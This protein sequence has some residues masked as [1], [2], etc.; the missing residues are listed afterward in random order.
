MG[1]TRF[2]ALAKYGRIGLLVTM[3]GFLLYALHAQL[4]AIADIPYRLRAEHLP[5]LLLVAL[6]APVNWGIEAYKW[7]WLT[8]GG[9]A[10]GWAQAYMAVLKGQASSLFAGDVLGGF[11]GRGDGV[12]SRSRQALIFPLMVSQLSQTLVSVGA[13]CI[14]IWVLLPFASIRLL[15][16][17]ILLLGG[18][19]LLWVSMR[20]WGPWILDRLWGILS[21]YRQAWRHVPLMDCWMAFILSVCR[22]VV[23][24][25]Q[26]LLLMRSLEMPLGIWHTCCCIAVMFLVKSILPSFAFVNDLLGRMASATAVFWYMGAPVENVLLAVTLLWLMNVAIPSLIGIYLWVLDSRHL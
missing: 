20:L 13:G 25:G 6:L 3:V 2:A 10:L 12:E 18:V 24:S 26:L 22:Y 19:L 8:K 1:R 14:G 16:V 5:C 21:P 4:H 23:F 9:A 15:W 7:R 17:S 11:L